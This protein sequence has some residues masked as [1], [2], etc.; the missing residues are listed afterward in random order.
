MLS[1][2]CE[3][4]YNLKME[5]SMK[6]KCTRCVNRGMIGDCVLCI[7]Y[8]TKRTMPKNGRAAGGNVLDRYELKTKAKR[9][10]NEQH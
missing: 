8:Y 10:Q 6:Q 4:D 5:I 7:H 3:R 1:L 9:T 2:N